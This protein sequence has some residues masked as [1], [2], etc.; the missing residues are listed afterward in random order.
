MKTYIKILVLLMFISA[1]GTTN[2]QQNDGE[3]S[4]ADMPIE[5]DLM[6]IS[7]SSGWHVAERYAAN[8]ERDLGVTVNVRD[9]SMGGLSLRQVLDRIAEHEVLKKTSDRANW[10]DYLAEAE[11]IVIYANPEGSVLE[12]DAEK[13]E[14]ISR[15]YHVE[16]CGLE[17]FD[18]YIEN[19]GLFYEKV[20]ELRE[21][22]PTL[23]RAFN[24]YIPIVSIWKEEGFYEECLHCWENYNLA[25]EMAAANYNVT[26]A[27]VFETFNGVDHDEDPRDKGFITYDGI[28]TTDAGAQAIADDLSTLGYD[29]T[30]P[31]QDN[32][33]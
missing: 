6:F 30:I 16:Y 20:F 8:I 23:I 18:P 25:I 33:N 29:I 2:N 14:C 9:W 12:S 21:G 5:W 10:I 22:K 3:L 26:V 15:P 24:A 11:V 13:W 1:C 17:T 4:F 31:P 27:P 32:K 19:L 28:H 7:D